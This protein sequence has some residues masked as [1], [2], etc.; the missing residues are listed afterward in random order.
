MKRLS[1]TTA[2]ALIALGA[3]FVQ[4]QDIP[5]G[6]LADL[7]GATASIGVAYANGIADTIDWYNENGGVDGRL[8]DFETVDYA[9]QAPRA[10]SI[11]QGWVADGVVAVFIR[12]MSWRRCG[13]MLDGTDEMRAIMASSPSR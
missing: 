12:S 11:Y 2:T 10:V 7:T 9:Y 5:V 3:G 8:I 13:T 1:L 4:A 6:H